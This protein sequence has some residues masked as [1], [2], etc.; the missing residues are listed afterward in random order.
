M[1]RVEGDADPRLTGCLLGI[2]PADQPVDELLAADRIERIRRQG[3]G[4]QPP[5]LV[6]LA[7]AGPD[8]PLEPGPSDRVEVGLIRDAFQGGFQEQVTFGW[9]LRLRVE[10]VGD[11]D[12]IPG[13]WGQDLL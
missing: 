4:H 11:E 5:C 7:E 6:T 1:A 12:G 9:L 10:L 13:A 3:L 2:P 8:L